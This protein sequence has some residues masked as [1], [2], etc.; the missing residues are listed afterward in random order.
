MR[1]FPFLTQ[2]TAQDLLLQL[3]VLM[4]RALLIH[5]YELKMNHT[6][7]GFARLFRRLMDRHFYE[8]N[9]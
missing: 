4:R 6:F 8:P 7:T 2:V 9:Q 1:A 5:S 3:E